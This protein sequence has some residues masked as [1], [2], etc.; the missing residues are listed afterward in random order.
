MKADGYEE[1]LKHSRWCLLKRPEK[2]TDNQIV[3]LKELLKYNLQ[4]VRAY[5]LKEDFQRFWEYVHPG[6]ATN[7]STRTC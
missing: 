2:L 4:A 6:W 5:L 3:K 7:C 1:V